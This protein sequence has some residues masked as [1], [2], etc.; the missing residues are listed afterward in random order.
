MNIL[1]N[2]ILV[3]FMGAGKSTIGKGLAAKIKYKYF[4]VDKWIEKKNRKNIVN[5][6]KEKGEKYF[7]KQEEKAL[8]WLKNKEGYVVSTGGGMWINELNRNKLLKMGL[9]IWLKISPETSFSRV[10][11]K[12][13]ERP[14]LLRQKQPLEHIKKL[15]SSRN[16]LYGLAHLTVNTDQK[17]P[18]EIID[19]IVELLK[20]KNDQ[21]DKR[22]T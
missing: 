19:E 6:F 20:S 1:R 8:E 14:L 17:E 2:I 5:I 12:L 13:Y 10:K 16:K 21:N 7:R 3:G 11:N 18:K 4:D 9:C 22:K 15:I